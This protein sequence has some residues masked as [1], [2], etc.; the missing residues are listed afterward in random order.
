MLNDLLDATWDGKG[1]DHVD[2]ALR[3]MA[4]YTVHHFATEED[5]MRTYRYPGYSEHKKAHDDLTAEVL[6]FITTCEEGGVTTELLVS[7][8]LRL[9]NWTRD[10][11]REMDQALGAFLISQQAPVRDMT[12]S[13]SEVRT[14]LVGGVTG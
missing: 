5:Y 11:I 10:H 2:K 8:V 7:V 9:G 1:K 4:N 13:G 3:F 14:R 6:R 12:F